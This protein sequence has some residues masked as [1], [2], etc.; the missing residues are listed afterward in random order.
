MHYV[1]IFSMDTNVAGKLLK[2]LKLLHLSYI[3]SKPFHE[4]QDVPRSI[5]AFI[6]AAI[7]AE[8]GSYKWVSGTF[9]LFLV[10]LKVRVRP[11]AASEG[12][13]NSSSLPSWQMD[14]VAAKTHGD[15]R[16]TR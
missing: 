12:I 5:E 6:G 7:C 14:G 11:G 9:I 13:N 15:E 16:L 3:K 10:D 8:R 2:E 4:G 1:E